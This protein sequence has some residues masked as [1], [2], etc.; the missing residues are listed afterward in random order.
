MVEVHVRVRPGLPGVHESVGARGEDDVAAI[1]VLKLLGSEAE[2]R[3][4]E[5]ALTSAGGAGQRRRAEQPQRLSVHD[6]AG[7]LV[8]L[9][10]GAGREPGR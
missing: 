5:L 2:L 10:L 9:H 1:S 6:R 8:A 7:V 4:M 3:A